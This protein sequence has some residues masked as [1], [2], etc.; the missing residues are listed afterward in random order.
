MSHHIRYIAYS[1]G[2]AG[3]YP[4]SA[5]YMQVY[6]DKLKQMLSIKFKNDRHSSVTRIQITQ[7]LQACLIRDLSNHYRLLY[8]DGTNIVIDLDQ[9]VQ[10]INK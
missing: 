2:Y 8:D 7:A 4:E 10:S 5:A 9:P 3:E 1:R 6:F